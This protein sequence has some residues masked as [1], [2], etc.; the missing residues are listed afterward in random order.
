MFFLGLFGGILDCQGNLM[1]SLLF[2]MNNE[3]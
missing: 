1:I 3:L 2:D